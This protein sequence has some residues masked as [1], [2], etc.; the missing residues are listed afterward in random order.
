MDGKRCSEKGNSSGRSGEKR[1]S[2]WSYLADMYSLPGTIELRVPKVGRAGRL[3]DARNIRSY[4]RKSV[5]K[6]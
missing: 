6:F 2:F 5:G 1:S 3:E 4:F